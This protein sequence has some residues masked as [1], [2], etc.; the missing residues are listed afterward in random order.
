MENDLGVTHCASEVAFIEN[1][2]LN[3]LKPPCL[4]R[5]RKI[6]AFAGRKIIQ[7]GNPVAGRKQRVD[8]VAADKSGSPGYEYVLI[9]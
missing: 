2:P 5:S 6:R 9:A 1:G 8:E 3:E 7:N 4:L